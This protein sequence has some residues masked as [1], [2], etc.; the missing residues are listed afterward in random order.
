MQC[1]TESLLRTKMKSVYQTWSL[2]LSSECWS[3]HHP[4]L[5]ELNLFVSVLIIPQL[6]KSGF[7]ISQEAINQKC[8]ASRCN[9]WCAFPIL[10]PS[11]LQSWLDRLSF[12]KQYK[13]WGYKLKE[14][15]PLF[16]PWEH[17]EGG[18]FQTADFL[19][20]FYSFNKHRILLYPFVMFSSTE[21]TILSQSE[22]YSLLSFIIGWLNCKNFKNNISFSIQLL[23]FQT[24]KGPYAVFLSPLHLACFFA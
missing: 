17:G 15:S 13:I 10:F 6:H 12:N 14:L 3:K 2:R 20:W 22:M 18:G 8:C 24:L 21:D 4:S 7:I 11:L 19:H 9:F 23:H 16:S 5:L 1:F